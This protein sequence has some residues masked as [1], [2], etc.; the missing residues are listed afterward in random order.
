MIHAVIYHYQREATNYFLFN[1][2]T[3]SIADTLLALSVPL[4]LITVPIEI[5]SFVLG[6]IFFIVSNWLYT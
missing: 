6:P 5:S 1:F 2:I 4:T 3:Q